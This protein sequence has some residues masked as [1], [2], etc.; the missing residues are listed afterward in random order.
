MLCFSPFLNRALHIRQNIML[1]Y[2]FNAGIK[3][4]NCSISEPWVYLM[5]LH[6]YNI[7]KCEIPL[8]YLFRESNPYF[9][10]HFLLANPWWGRAVGNSYNL[11][12]KLKSLEKSFFPLSPTKN[13]NYNFT[14][15]TNLRKI[16]LRFQT[17]IKNLNITFDSVPEVKNQI[18]K[19][20]RLATKSINC[21]LTK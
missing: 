7:F 21:T 2:N 19:F 10:L 12:A 5:R 14:Y 18:S 11:I 13:I 20:S 4:R 16:F 17:T 15:T 3:Q 9:H 8:I 1:F 6:I